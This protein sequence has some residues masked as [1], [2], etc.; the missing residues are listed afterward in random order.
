MDRLPLPC[1]HQHSSTHHVLP[2]SAR[3]IPHVDMAAEPNNKPQD[4]EPQLSEAFNS[5][6][7]P[8]GSAH[9]VSPHTPPKG[10]HAEAQRKKERREARIWLIHKAGLCGPETSFFHQQHGPHKQLALSKGLLPASGQ[11]IKRPGEELSNSFSRTVLQSP[12]P[13]GLPGTGPQQAGDS[14]LLL[15]VSHKL[16]C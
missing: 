14:G 9:H 12:D 7:S 4:S 1:L 2:K 11:R 8:L 3:C 15:A 16:H 10:T 6:S 5:P 13:E